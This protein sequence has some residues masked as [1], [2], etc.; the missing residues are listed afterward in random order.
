MIECAAKGSIWIADLSLAITRI[1]ACRRKGALSASIALAQGDRVLGNRKRQLPKCRAGQRGSIGISMNSSM[2][3][4]F[5]SLFR[6]VLEAAPDSTLVIDEAG[7]IIFANAATSRVLGWKTTDLIGSSVDSLL[8]E[9]LRDHHR[10]L[11]GRFLSEPA[12]RAMGSARE[13]VAQRADGTDLPVEISLNPIP[14]ED[15]IRVICVVRDISERKRLDRELRD[16]NAN[17]ERRVEERTLQLQAANQ[18]LE[19]L[20]YSI[21]HD[22]RAPLRAI[23]GF[24]TRLLD[25]DNG[26][27]KDEARHFVDTIVSRTVQ[28]S[29]MIDDYLNLLHV[30]RVTLES[31]LVDMTALA[32]DVLQEIEGSQS[33]V[34]DKVVLDELPSLVADRKLLRTLWLQ[35]LDNAFKFRAQDR[36]LRIAIA[37]LKDVRGVHFT[38]RD[39]GVGFDADHAAKLFRPFERLNGQAYPGNG[40]GLCLVRRI[41]ERL[42][43]G[44]AIDGRVDEGATISFWLPHKP[45]I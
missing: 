20:S 39:N 10:Q 43:G 4:A 16:L 12:I 42:E 23:H 40:I 38:V 17:L 24:S 45:L 37:A 5:F 33:V 41:A 36:P 19:M 7:R 44:V 32:R 3:Q 25:V 35:I 31:E 18:E 29:R 34:G 26:D 2:H 14:A 22:L 1:P 11:R 15:G 30:G 21:A 27:R 9:R 6:G 28:M 13:L 8:P